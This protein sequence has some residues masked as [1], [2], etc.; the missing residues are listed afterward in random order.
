MS[1]GRGSDWT[2]PVIALASYA[3]VIFWHRLLSERNIG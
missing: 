1:C 2:G 3:A